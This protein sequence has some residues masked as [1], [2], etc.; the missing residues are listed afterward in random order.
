MSYAQII[1]LGRKG[2]NPVYC[3]L[4][5]VLKS[6]PACQVD[7]GTATAGKAVPSAAHRLRCRACRGKGQRAHHFGPCPQKWVDAPQARITCA[8]VGCSI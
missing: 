2:C 5:S 4:E 6:C 8:S 3:A 1:T 7:Q